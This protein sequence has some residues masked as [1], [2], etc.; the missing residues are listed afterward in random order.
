M[1]STQ[2]PNGKALFSA[3]HS[4]LSHNRDPAGNLFI[5]SVGRPTK[6]QPYIGLLDWCHVFSNLASVS[7]PWC[8]I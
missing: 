2:R 3:G 1:K 7:F 4:P 6:P 5:A 8:G